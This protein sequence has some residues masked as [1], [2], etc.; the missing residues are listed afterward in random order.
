M[1]LTQMKRKLCFL[2]KFAADNMKMNQ[3]VKHNLKLLKLKHENF[4]KPNLL[5]QTIDFEKHKELIEPDGY[6]WM[7]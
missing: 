2:D 7:L 1:N 6:N 3:Q 4:E 5:K